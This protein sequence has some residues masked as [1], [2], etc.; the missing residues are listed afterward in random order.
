MTA[1]WILGPS[2]Q[3]KSSR[4]PK[5]PELAGPGGSLEC[6]EAVGDGWRTSVVVTGGEKLA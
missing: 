2:D 5:K 6:A 4:R 3:S 1:P